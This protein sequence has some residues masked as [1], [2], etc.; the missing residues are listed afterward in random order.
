MASLELML[1]SP[2]QT[3]AGTGSEFG[4]T[5]TA[6]EDGIG[7]LSKL[8][9]SL[10]GDAA[11]PNASLQLWKFAQVRQITLDGADL[12]VRGAN[13]PGIPM[14][15]WG[16]DRQGIIAGLPDVA[17]RSQGT[18]KIA[19]YYTYAGGVG[20]FSVG[21]PFTP[22]S[23]RDLA[24]GAPLRGPEVMAGSPDAA[25][26]DDTEVDLTC[27]FDTSGVFDFSR[28]VISA[29]LPPTGNIHASDG[30]EYVNNLVIRQAILR[31]DY[32]NVIGVGAA[33]FGAG[34]FNGNRQINWLE[35]GRHRVTSGDALVVTVYQLSGITARASF[36]VPMT[37][38]GGGVP[39]AS[40]Q[41]K[42][43]C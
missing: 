30:A 18:L 43:G 9:C 14:S 2:I 36:S 3:T 33:E 29:S 21:I 4:A 23:K 17:M 1:G 22:V 6:N 39:S 26:A 20:D 11:V 8:L 10:R 41:P 5:I 15:Q 25:V 7:K 19:G 37:V 13:T 32:N 27:T 38:A 31:S 40:N 28:M 34:Y 16:P 12:Y 24:P 35:L 42:C